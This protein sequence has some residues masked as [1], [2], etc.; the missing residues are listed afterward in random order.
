MC[1]HLCTWQEPTPPPAPPHTLYASGDG[2]GGRQGTRTAR[3]LGTTSR[4]GRESLRGPGE[5]QPQESLAPRNLRR[6]LQTA[7]RQ[8]EKAGSTLC[9]QKVSLD[10]IRLRLTFQRQLQRGGQ[11]V[12]L[13]GKKREAMDSSVLPQAPW[14]SACPGARSLSA[15]SL[16]QNCN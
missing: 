13:G 12:G 7:R 2:A 15:S 10:G 14:L 1:A 11:V 8:W 4:R 3:R 9:S 5:A 6:T 16:H